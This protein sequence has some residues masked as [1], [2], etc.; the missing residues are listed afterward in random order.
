MHWRDDFG[1]FVIVMVFFLPAAISLFFAWSV[2]ISNKRPAIARWRLIAFRW[3]LVSAVMTT[4]VFAVTSVHM[5]RS[6][7]NATGSGSSQIG[8]A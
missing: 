6:L 7:E 2:W 5:I 4:A 1:A 3:G 8:L